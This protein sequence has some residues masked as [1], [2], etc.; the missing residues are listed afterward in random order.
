[1]SRIFIPLIIV[2][3]AAPALA[4]QATQSPSATQ[5]GKMRVQWRQLLKY[6]DY[7]RDA[8]GAGRDIEQW[9]LHTQMTLGLSSNLSIQ[10]DLP[11][12][13][14]RAE[15]GGVEDREEG[16]DDAHLMLKWR[17]W[18]NDIGP[19][20]TQRLSLFVGSQVPTGQHPF[21]S[22]SF[23]P[24][25][26]LAFTQ[27]RGRHGTGAALRYHVTT[28]SVEGLPVDAGDS[29]DDVLH[30]DASYLYRIYPTQ[31]TADTHGGLYAMV[32]LNGTYETN[33]DH[34]MMIAPGIMYEARTW[35]IEL[36]FQAPLWQEIDHRV[37]TDFTFTLGYRVLF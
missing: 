1:M 35:V 24:M 21:S 15:A 32:E 29:I 31:F 8:T 22:N 2:A 25:V 7:G 18:T 27:V 10:A 34:Q 19:I 5:P 30:Y 37:E 17:F 16:F 28:D 11:V 36:S 3:V 12:L 20:D 26:G 4:Q 13:F 6:T 33:G 14:D 9:H 23:D